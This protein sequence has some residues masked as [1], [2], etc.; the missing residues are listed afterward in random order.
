MWAKWVYSLHLFMVEYPKKKGSNSKSDHQKNCH[1]IKE[2]KNVK[3]FKVTWGLT[4]LEYF[5]HYKT[6]SEANVPSPEDMMKIMYHQPCIVA[7]ESNSH[8]PIQTVL[9]NKVINRIFTVMIFLVLPTTESERS[10]NSQP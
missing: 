2:K 3:K 5:L 8:I 10:L 9:Y 6:L 4:F 7:L 1:C